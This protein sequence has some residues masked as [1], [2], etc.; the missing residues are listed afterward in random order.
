MAAPLKKRAVD[1]SSNFNGK[2]AKSESSDEG[3][4][5]SGLEENINQEV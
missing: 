4:D 3:S 1:V 5:G 2:N